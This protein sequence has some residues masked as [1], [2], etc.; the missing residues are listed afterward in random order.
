MDVFY[1]L[2]V[3]TK[4]LILS[5]TKTVE[6]STIK[7]D[8]LLNVSRDNNV[9]KSAQFGIYLQLCY[10]IFTHDPRTTHTSIAYNLER[11][12]ILPSNHLSNYFQHN[13]LNVNTIYVGPGVVKIFT[14]WCWK[15]STNI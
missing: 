4:Y 10:D 9:K 11:N 6:K 8:G 14:R 1:F 3:R 5:L 13:V 2:I 7:I 15:K 12:A